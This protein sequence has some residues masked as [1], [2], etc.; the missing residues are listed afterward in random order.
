MPELG[1]QVTGIDATIANL[2]RI[3][4]IIVEAFDAAARRVTVESIQVWRRGMRRRTGKMVDLS[5]VRIVQSRPLEI[6][7]VYVTAFYYGF[8]A[9]RDVLNN[10]LVQWLHARL[11]AVLTE[12]IRLRFR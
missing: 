7:V 11:P 2:G 6:R 8:Q 10:Q 12:E 4:G 1:L 9:N 3:H 5:Q